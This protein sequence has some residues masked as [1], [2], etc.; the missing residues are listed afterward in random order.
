MTTSAKAWRPSCHPDLMAPLAEVRA[1]LEWRA[2]VV[3]GRL[4]PDSPFPDSAPANVQ[5]IVPVSFADPLVE[6]ETQPSPLDRLCRL[7]GLSA[8]ERSLLL[9]CAGVELDPEFSP[10]CAAA[11]GDTRTPYPTFSL[12][13]SLFA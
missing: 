7:F 10:L 13:L 5:L 3:A 9:L 4:A 8:F 1:A 6:T 2:E 12:A 11:R